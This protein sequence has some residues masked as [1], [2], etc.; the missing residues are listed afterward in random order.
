MLPVCFSLL[1]CLDRTVSPA[2]SNVLE[3]ELERDIQPKILL[4]T[5]PAYPEW[6]VDQGA[7][8]SVEVRAYLGRDSTIH[9]LVFTRPAHHPSFDTAVAR[10]LLASR[11]SANGDDGQPIEGWFSMRYRFLI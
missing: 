6:A 7:E 4:E 1:G 10:A 9:R 3:F 5:M 8:D 11:F 2:P